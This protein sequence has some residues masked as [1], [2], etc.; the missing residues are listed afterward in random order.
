MIRDH[1]L[2]FLLCRFLRSVSSLNF[3]CKPILSLST[4]DQLNTSNSTATSA[5]NVSSLSTQ[6]LSSTIT[7]SSSSSFS[8]P[9]AHRSSSAPPA[10]SPAS[11]QKLDFSRKSPSTSASISYGGSDAAAE[12]TASS[13]VDIKVPL[14]PSTKHS[15]INSSSSSICSSR[16][17]TEVEAFRGIMPKVE[18]ANGDGER[19]T[20][21][22]ANGIY[23]EDTK[24]RLDATTANILKR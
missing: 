20:A 23:G 1:I 11:S 12:S 21:E 3:D 24:K 14:L 17:K 5:S 22:M 9:D 10:K 19:R 15:T 6:P 7:S 4:N 16:L 13:A 8:S 18:S 2:V